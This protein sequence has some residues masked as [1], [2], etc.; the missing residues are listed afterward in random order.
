MFICNKCLGIKYE[1]IRLDFK[2]N[3]EA[4]DEN[5]LLCSL[6]LINMDED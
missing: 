1:D 3:V 4:S 2:W 5:I 6:E